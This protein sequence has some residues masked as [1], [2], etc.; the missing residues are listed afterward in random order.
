MMFSTERLGRS[1]AR[2]AIISALAIVLQAI[3]A[4]VQALR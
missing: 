2:W 3:V 1:L 4:L